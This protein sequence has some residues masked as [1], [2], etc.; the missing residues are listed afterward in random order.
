[1]RLRAVLD[2]SVLLGAQRHELIYLAKKKVYI[3]LWCSF[4]IGEVA[5]VRTERAIEHHQDRKIYRARVNLLISQLSEVMT[6]VNYRRFEG[7]T[8]TR[9]LTDSDDE[10]LLAAA[11][12]GK[13]QYIVSANTRDFPP[14]GLWA[15]VRY[16]TAPDF[17]AE[18][19]SQHP[20]G[21]ALHNR[22]TTEDYRIP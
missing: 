10:P 20:R 18:L 3:A 6:F 17:I 4:L 7:G 9:W 21:A 22:F 12:V 5:R 16:L 1:M 15:G 11:L 14:N 13:A 2:T 8:H 19:Y